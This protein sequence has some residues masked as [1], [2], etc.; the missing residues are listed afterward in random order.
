MTNAVATR[1]SGKVV[2]REA[3]ITL[4]GASLGETP[5]PIAE[6]R[7]ASSPD[8]FTVHRCQLPVASA[9]GNR[10]ADIIRSLGSTS[11]TVR[12]AIHAFHQQALV[13]LT[14]GSPYA[15][16]AVP[17]FHPGQK[18]AP[19]RDHPYQSL[20]CFGEASG[21]GCWQIPSARTLC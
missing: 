14:T 17:G 20:R 1:V 11:Q 3:W 9:C 12:N 21:A 19:A 7:L 15:H 5:S 8:T 18:Q 10:S 16:Q 13:C 2:P 4:L 6:G